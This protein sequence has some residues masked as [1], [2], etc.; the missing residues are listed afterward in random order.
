M[1]EYAHLMPLSGHTVY[2]SENPGEAPD[3][4]T[5]TL[6]HQLKCLEIIHREY[7]DPSLPLIPSALL[8]HCLNYLRQ[9]ILCRP[10]LRLES[11][12][13]RSAKSAQGY[14][15]VCRDWTEVYEEA[16]RNNR[17]YFNT[18]NSTE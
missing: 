17:V 1:K 9:T 10:N 13:T 18:G 8:S 16:E 7:L 14:E 2:V 12:T 11:V 15:A 3:V 4:Y 6:F 5:V